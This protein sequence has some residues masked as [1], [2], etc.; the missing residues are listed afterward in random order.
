MKDAGGGGGGDLLQS[1]HWKFLRGSV[2]A[3]FGYFASEPSEPEETRLAVLCFLCCCFVRPPS[4]F[5]FPFFN[6]PL[7]PRASFVAGSLLPNEVKGMSVDATYT[8]RN[9]KWRSSPG[10]A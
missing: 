10:A 3:L 9:L 6:P 4:L 5:F 2:F 7:S 8:E 1:V